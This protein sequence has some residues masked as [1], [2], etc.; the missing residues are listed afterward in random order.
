MR[1]R[2]YDFLVPAGVDATFFRKVSQHGVHHLIV[3]HTYMRGSVPAASDKA[4][5][6][7][8]FQMMGQG[9]SGDSEF[10]L[11]LADAAPVAPGPDQHAVDRKPGGVPKRFKAAG[12]LFKVTHTIQSMRHADFC[13]RYF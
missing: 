13:Q 5:Q 12:C 8:M 11:N 7:Q 1:V 10:V 6:F 3:R 2:G 9:R 4:D